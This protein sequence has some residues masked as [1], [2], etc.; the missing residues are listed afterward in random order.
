MIPQIEALE[1]R[2]A[3]AGVLTHLPDGQALVVGYWPPITNPPLPVIP[4]G[5]AVIPPPTQFTATPAQLASYQAF[6]AAQ[7]IPP[8]PV[9]PAQMGFGAYGAAWLAAHHEG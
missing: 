3:P 7:Q 5:Y 6:F 9:Q 2:Y 8:P 1:P 4:T